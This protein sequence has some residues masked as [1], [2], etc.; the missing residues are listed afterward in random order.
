MQAVFG[1]VESYRAWAIHHPVGDLD[2]AVSRQ[3]VHVDR[4]RFGQGHL[5]L[6]GD[7]MRVFLDDLGDLL[8]IWCVH[9]G[10]PGLGVDDV[11]VFKGG[12]HIIHNLETCAELARLLARLV[13]DL[14]H[15][16]KLR[17][18]CQNHVQPE[19]WHLEHQALR[20]GHRLLVRSRISPGYD[21]L[22]ASQVAAL[23]LYDGH[24]VGQNLEGMVDFALHVEHR[25]AG[26]LGDIVEITVSY[27]PVHVADGDAVEVPP[28]DLADLLRCISMC[29]LGVFR[30][31]ECS[32]PAQLSHPRLEGTPRARARKK[33]QHCQ[34]LIAQIGMRLAQGAVTLQVESDVQYRL[35]FFFAECE[36]A[37][38]APVS[39]IGLHFNFSCHGFN[40]Y[41]Y[42]S[43]QSSGRFTSHYS[44]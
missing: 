41:C 23:L 16:F 3:R 19:A 13:H 10:A 29:D 44:A 42:S 35:D 7:P 6:I 43:N 8:R 26:S 34:H 1:F 9:H 33:E 37:D 30:L 4:V 12:L 36:V 14:R 40:L 17:W 15:Q 2:I 39:Q 28:E 21:H 11:G 32:V 22:L 25:D 20:H 5:A 27:S 31:Y 18:M 24:Q 38:Q